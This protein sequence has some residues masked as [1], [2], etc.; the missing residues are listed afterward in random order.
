MIGLFGVFYKNDLL[1]HE[2]DSL[3]QATEYAR[4]LAWQSPTELLIVELKREVIS[5]NM[6]SVE[7]RDL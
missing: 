1:K 5:S 2:F 7:N 4:N 6:L 3:E